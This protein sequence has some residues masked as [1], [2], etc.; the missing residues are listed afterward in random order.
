MHKPTHRYGPGLVLALTLVLGAGKS[1]ALDV[2]TF[3]TGNPERNEVIGALGFSI[4]Q[5]GASAVSGLDFSMYDVI[6]V[7]QSYEEFLTSSLLGALGSRSGDLAEF[8]ANGGGIVFGS[9]AAGGNIGGSVVSTS[10]THDVVENV[11]LSTLK[12][13]LL[14]EIPILDPVATYSGTPVI[15]TGEL[16]D[17]RVVTWNPKPAGVITDESLQLVSNSITW[18]SGTLESIPEPGTYA[19]FGLGAVA[20]FFF[21]RRLTGL[22]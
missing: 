10:P 1:Q 2:L 5:V 19:L 3:D 7:A 9:P 21:R 18:A 20:L 12:L 17:G 6:Y 22:L 4:T 11:D 15:S 8:V 14:P 13:N 16:G